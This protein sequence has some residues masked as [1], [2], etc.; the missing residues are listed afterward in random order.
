M[1]GPNLAGTPQTEDFNLGRGRLFIGELDVTTKLPTKG[2]RDIGNVPEF[3]LTV[4]TETLEHRSSRT[5]LAVVDKEVVIS[6]K[7]NGSFRFDE[8]SYENMAEFFAGVQALYDNS[9]AVSAITGDDNLTVFTHGRW[10]DLYAGVDGSGVRLYDIGALTV[11]DKTG[12]TTYVLGTDYNVDL[13][14]GRIFIIT[15]GSIAFDE[16]GSGLGTILDIITAANAGA[17][18]S[19][20]EVRGLA[21]SPPEIALLFIGENPA[22]NDTQVEFL[23]HAVSLKADGDFGLISD[24]WT[25][26]GVTFVA[27][28]N[29]TASPLSPTLTIRSH[30]NS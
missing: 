26:M 12:V 15:A 28:T 27:G 23:F 11:K 16:E 21:Q 22:N 9:A 4:E 3:A 6:Q 2:Y 1:P 24:D 30:D 29:V 5:G 14:W 19:F 20:S 13:K 8:L 7:L 10:Y 18:A 17:D 25:Q